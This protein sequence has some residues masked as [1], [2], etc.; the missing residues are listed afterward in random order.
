MAT[1]DSILDRV[2]GKTIEE[3]AKQGFSGVIMAIGV[4]V[5]SGVLSIGELLTS[6]ID[7]LTRVFGQVIQSFFV[8]PLSIIAEAALASAQSV[9]PGGEW[10]IGPFTL[11]LGL[12][13]VL[14]FFW[15]L[16]R[17]LSEDETSNV[18]PGLP[19]DLGFWPFRDEEASGDD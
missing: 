7:A 4:S 18:A 11:L 17:Y 19:F 3:V 10:T 16:A 14:A 9:G 6:P 12:V 15:I 13:T 1:A 2:A 8:T 5:I